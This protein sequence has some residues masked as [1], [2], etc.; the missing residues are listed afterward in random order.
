MTMHEPLSNQLQ[1]AVLKPV[2]DWWHGAR[3]VWAR[4]D[5]VET[6]SGD[7]IAWMAEDVGMAR[8]DLVL[9]LSR[10][11]GPADLL[12]RRLAALDIDPE[13]IRRI[14]PLL[15]ADL[16]RTCA[17]CKDRDRCAEEMKDDP[18]P[19]GWES[20]CPNAGTLRTLT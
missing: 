13:D 3:S 1:T 17:Q 10:P 12:H 5:Q 15:L 18:L 7:E 8:D 11:D 4:A 9:M 2:L 20:Y 16:E 14:S 6:L 19:A